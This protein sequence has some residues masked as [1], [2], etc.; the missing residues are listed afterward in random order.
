MGRNNERKGSIAFN[1]GGWRVL[2][3]RRFFSRLNF[4]AGEDKVLEKNKRGRPPIGKGVQANTQLRPELARAVDDWITAQPSPQPTRS[5]AIRE[6]IRLGLQASGLDVP[7]SRPPRTLDER[8]EKARERASKP[9]PT[10][11]ASP[12]K[13]LAMLEKGNAEAGLAGLKV[14]ESKS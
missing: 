14:K 6:L 12:Q 13:G 10:G 5:E 7:D 8:I 11:A 2:S 3:G 4:M 9:T 1:G